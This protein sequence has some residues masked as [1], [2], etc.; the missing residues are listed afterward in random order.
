MAVEFFLSSGLA[1][2]QSPITPYVVGTV[3]NSVVWEKYEKNRILQYFRKSAKKPVLSRILQ[4]DG[5]NSAVWQI[6]PHIGDVP[7]IAKSVNALWFYAIFCRFSIVKA[8]VPALL[9]ARS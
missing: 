5:R 7:K 3:I 4:P 2:C 8:S 1:A 9:Q 6:F